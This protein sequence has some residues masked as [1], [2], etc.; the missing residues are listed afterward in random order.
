M[1][2]HVKSLFPVRLKDMV[3]NILRSLNNN[4][5]GLPRDL[6][7]LYNKNRFEKV[8]IKLC[9]KDFYLPDSTSF[10]HMYKDIFF[11]D[12]YRFE[13]K[14]TRPLIIDVG[15]NIGLSLVY[16]KNIF[17]ESRILAFEP[18]PEIFEYLQKN[19]MS[20]DNIELINKGVYDEAMEIDFVSDHADGGSIFQNSKDKIKIET[21]LLSDFL[22]EKVDF[23]KIDIE[24][25]ETKVLRE[26]KDKLIN[27]DNL[28]IEY[29]SFELS[30]Q[31]LHEILEIITSAGFRY[32]ISDVPLTSINPFMNVSKVNNMDMQ[33]NISCIRN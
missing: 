25:A 32:Y 33:I 19:I 22:T 17:P 7:F 2:S 28:F 26:C 31:T 18:D 20:L 27:V 3:K 16:F 12:I 9:G 4:P 11:R 29:H 24:G 1:L 15:A 5:C 30:N 8:K 6:K 21:C 23:L 13:S 14:C 10:I